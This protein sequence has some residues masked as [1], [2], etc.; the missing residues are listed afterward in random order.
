MTSAAH[1]LRSFIGRA[2]VQPTPPP[3]DLPRHL[4]SRSAALFIV[5]ACVL[6]LAPIGFV[7]STDRDVPHMPVYLKYN[8][9]IACLFPRSVAIWKSYHVQYQR[10]GHGD[11]AVWHELPGL[12]AFQLSNFGYRTRLQRILGQAYQKDRGQRRTRELAEYIRRKLENGEGPWAGERVSPLAIRFVRASQSVAT[13]AKQK[14][15]YRRPDLDDI[16]EAS[17]QIFGENR[18][19][20]KRPR[21]R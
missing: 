19:D 20:G 13:L 1:K 15:A 21:W 3:S 10:R 11:E 12:D 4:Y 6:W 7:G 14:G 5:I 18:W 8:Q 17:W 16:P 2:I 9:R